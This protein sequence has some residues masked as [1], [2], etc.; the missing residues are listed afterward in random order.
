MIS[1]FIVAIVAFLV[2]FIQL[3]EYR[4][5]PDRLAI[6]QAEPVHW[7][8]LDKADI[9]HVSTWKRIVQTNKTALLPKRMVV[10]ANRWRRLNPTWEYAFFDDETAERVINGDPRAALALQNLRKIGAAGAAVADLFRAVEISERGGWYVDMDCGA[11]D[12]VQVRC[13]DDAIFYI[14]HQGWLCHWCFFAKP[15]HPIMTTL[16]E[17]VIARTL[18]THTWTPGP[19]IFSVTGPGVLEEVAQRLLPLARHKG[20]WVAG[21]YTL[22]SGHCVRLEYTSMLPHLK[23]K[24]VTHGIKFSRLPCSQ[25]YYGAS[26]DQELVSPHY[27]SG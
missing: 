8:S 9:S 11:I 1:A 7:S 24:W 18:S 23:F 4:V 22:D 17:E 13:S 10:E 20:Q 6:R 21:S 16:K 25:K 2:A 19:Q 12:P 27:T 5:V 3:L 15:K 14:E 26:F